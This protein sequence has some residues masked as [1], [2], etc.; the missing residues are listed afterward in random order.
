MRDDVR[1]ALLSD[2]PIIADNQHIMQIVENC[3]DVLMPGLQK[4]PRWLF[5]FPQ[6]LPLQIFSSAHA[7]HRL[8]VRIARMVAEILDAAFAFTW[9]GDNHLCSRKPGLLDTAHNLDLPH[10]RTNACRILNI[11]A[12]P[13]SQLRR[14]TRIRPG[15]G[16]RT[17]YFLLHFL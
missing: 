9:H 7:S 4:M 2:P 12:G 8:I 13:Q 16:K 1:L 5:P 6:P 14:A 3:A 11:A 10:T 15:Q 17:L